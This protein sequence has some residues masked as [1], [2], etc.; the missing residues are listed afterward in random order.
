MNSWPEIFSQDYHGA[1]I[2]LATL[3]EA[4]TQ[5]LVFA[6]VELYPTEIPLPPA[7]VRPRRQNADDAT[8][9]VSVTAVSLDEGLSWYEGALA[10]DLKVPGISRAI[11]LTTV[12]LAAEPGIGRLLLSNDAPCAR[13]WHGGLRANRLVPM[14][15]L[16]DQ[17][18]RLCVGEEHPQRKKLRAWFADLLGFDVLAHDDFVGGLILMAPNPVTRSVATYI[19]DIR[20]EG[21]EV[22]S[23]KASVRR[24]H[25]AETLSIRL[26]EERPGGTAIVERR[27]DRFGMAEIEIPEQCERTGVQLVCDRRGVLSL[28][29]PGYFLRSISVSSQTFQ[30]VGQIDVP[31]RKKGEASSKQP[32]IS[33]SAGARAKP[34]P[35]VVLGA[36][37]QLRNLQARRDK[38][39]GVLAPGR[40]SSSTGGKRARLLEQ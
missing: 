26:R 20:A 23:V 38:R 22:L 34:Q 18:A 12:E 32:L 40:I 29:A 28:E 15:A 8:G 6:S 30:N 9:T 2:R 4:G 24:G 19:K 25:D 7:E 11:S 14:S 3:T 35:Q 39:T 21:G 16:P 5:Y 10:G 31:G 17:V 27:L 1:V 36:A 13:H 33:K 37:A